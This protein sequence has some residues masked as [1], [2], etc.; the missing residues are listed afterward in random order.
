[1]KTKSHYTFVGRQTISV[2]IM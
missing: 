2:C 1:M